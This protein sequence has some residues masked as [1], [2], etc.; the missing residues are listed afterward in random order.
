[1]LVGRRRA[2][3]MTHTQA[4]LVKNRELEDIAGRLGFEI[5]L[6]NLSEFAKGGAM[7]SGM[8]MLWGSKTRCSVLTCAPRALTGHG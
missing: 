4:E 1:M 2:W 5:A 7:L 3:L 6:I 8:V